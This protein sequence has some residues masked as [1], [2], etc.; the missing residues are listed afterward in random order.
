MG[1]LRRIR[2]PLDEYLSSA[3][4]RAR[5]EATTCPHGGL[6]LQ[7]NPKVSKS[8]AIRARQ[9]RNLPQTYVLSAFICEES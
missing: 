2:E 4:E 9:T 5:R 8:L 3:L 7:I 1:V 6:L